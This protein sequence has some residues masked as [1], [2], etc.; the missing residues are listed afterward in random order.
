MG[1]YL[2]M[3]FCPPVSREHSYHIEIHPPSLTP[4]LYDRWKCTGCSISV[5]TWI[6]NKIKTKQINDLLVIH[7]ASQAYSNS[8]SS[9]YTFTLMS[10]FAG[11]IAI[12]TDPI[13][14]SFPLKLRVNYTDIDRSVGR[15]ASWWK[16]L[17][18]WDRCTTPVLWIA[19]LTFFS[20]FNLE[21]HAILIHAQWNWSHNN[22]ILLALVLHM[23]VL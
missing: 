4:L 22:C 14:L 7:Q 9:A 2:I 18:P 13:L 16:S 6:I 17:G 1:T 20:V 21:D 5:V 11:S 19:K 23:M 8:G 12:C 15:L 10:Q 3:V